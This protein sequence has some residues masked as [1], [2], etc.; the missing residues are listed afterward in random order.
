MMSQIIGEKIVKLLMNNVT[1]KSILI[2]NEDWSSMIL[3][4]SESPKIRQCLE[5]ITE[6]SLLKLGLTGKMFGTSIFTQRIVAPSHYYYLFDYEF[7]KKINT[8]KIILNN[9]LEKNTVTVHLSPSL[10]DQFKKPYY[11]NKN[12][13]FGF[14]HNEHG[15]ALDFADQ[16]LNQYYLNNIHYSYKEW[17]TIV[18]K[19]EKYK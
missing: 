1:N 4:M 17:F 2:N 5:I 6:G 7:G 15:P 10:N 9:F 18:N 12:D 11:D 3:Y 8:N 19:L 13:Y 16:K 14:I